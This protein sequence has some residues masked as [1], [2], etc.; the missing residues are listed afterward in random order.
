MIPHVKYNVLLY[1]Q[2]QLWVS[3]DHGVGDDEEQNIKGIEY[4]KRLWRI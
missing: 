4:S 2:Y 1:F 3:F